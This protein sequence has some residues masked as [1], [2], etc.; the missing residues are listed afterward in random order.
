M[1]VQ[2]LNSIIEPLREIKGVQ[3]KI[4][5]ADDRVR[6][7]WKIDLEKCRLSLARTRPRSLDTHLG[8]KNWFYTGENSY[9]DNE[10]LKGA[11][12]SISFA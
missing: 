11:E 3:V 10:S 4:H 7:G 9:L 1:T 5:L 2:E 8:R 6:L 12:L